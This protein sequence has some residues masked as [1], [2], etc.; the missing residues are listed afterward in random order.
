MGH[1]PVRSD[2]ADVSI[3]WN[4]EVAITADFFLARLYDVPAM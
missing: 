1:P 3:V 4:E 2:G